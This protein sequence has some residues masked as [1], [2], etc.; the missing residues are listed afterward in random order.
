M[1]RFIAVLLAL[2]FLASLTFANAESTSKAEGKFK[3]TFVKTIGKNQSALQ[4]MLS[5]S[6]RA[7]FAVLFA[8]DFMNEYQENL[9]KA[10]Y[11]FR[12]LLYGDMYVGRSLNTLI[13]AYKHAGNNDFII[14]LFDT[15]G[16]EQIAEFA[17]YDND[18]K[19]NVNSFIETILTEAAINGYYKVEPIDLQKAIN[20]IK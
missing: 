17:V 16:I 15:A 4:W 14:M 20:K 11:D 7:L 13:L 18:S 9:D 5:E 2:I 10:P 6:N 19:M 12:D 1:K 8:F 3:P